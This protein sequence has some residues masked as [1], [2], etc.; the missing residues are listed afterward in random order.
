MCRGGVYSIRTPPRHNQNFALAVSLRLRT[1]LGQHPVFIPT[2]ALC[3]REVSRNKFLAQRPFVFLVCSCPPLRP[4]RPE[5]L[6]RQPPPQP[7]PPAHRLRQAARRHAPQHPPPVRH[8]RYRPDPR[9]HHPRPA[10]CR[11]AR[12]Q[13][14]PH[15]R[16][17]GR[18]ARAAARSL[19]HASPPTRPPGRREADPAGCLPTPEQIAAEVRRRP[20]GAVI[21]D[22]CRDLGIMPDHP[23]WRELQHLIICYG[24]SLANLVKDILDRAFQRRASRGLRAR[25]RR[26]AIPRP[27]GTG[28]P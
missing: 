12:S 11:G 2:D 6:P 24:G 7:R 1:I 5:A 25:P 26:P 15:S 4:P 13:D 22:I 3:K 23:L 8:Q 27:S 19:R 16:P 10:P 9:A 28:P 18:R 14:H 17:A 21:A 20:I